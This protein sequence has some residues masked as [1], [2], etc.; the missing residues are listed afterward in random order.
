MFSMRLLWLLPCAFL[1]SEPA[2]AI[3]VYSIEGTIPNGLTGLSINDDEPFS[4]SLTYTPVGAAYT[5]D[6]KLNF[7]NRTLQGSFDNADS[8]SVVDVDPELLPN[9]GDGF[10]PEDFIW[11]L[12]DT[13]LLN[14]N[15]LLAALPGSSWNL[16]L[17]DL[18][19][20]SSS[21]SLAG[22]LNS[23]SLLAVPVPPALWFFG[24]G[25]L[26]LAGVSGR[27]QAG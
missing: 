15:A 14:E 9:P 18:N 6:Y 8:G 3:S 7:G 24:T 12:S 26:G 1:L 10:F 27:K 25:L 11:Y 23:A 21:G 4:G 17:L 13:A 20:F 2:H 19:D 16:E 5:L 22:T